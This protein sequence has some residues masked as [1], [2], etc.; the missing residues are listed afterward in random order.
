MHVSE[1]FKRVFG[2]WVSAVEKL[3]RF[4]GSFD[5]SFGDEIDGRLGDVKPN[6]EDG[7]DG[8]ECGE[9]CNGSKREKQV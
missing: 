9:P 6:E 3:E 5:A 8:E 1:R 2:L 7:R 4:C